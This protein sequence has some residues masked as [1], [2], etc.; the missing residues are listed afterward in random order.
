LR[1]WVAVSLALYVAYWLELDN[2]YWAGTTAAIVC[3]PSLGASL[4][5]A[6]FRMIGT[7]IGAVAV[8]V[9]TACFPQSRAG[10]LIGLA[11]WGATCGFMATLLRNFASYAAALAGYTAVIIASDELAAT[12]SAAGEIFTLAVTRASEICI[13]I[14]CAGV[15]LA[16][17]DFGQARRRLA[18]QFAAISAEIADGLAGTF[19]L[20]GAV[21][22][23]TLPVR[24]DLLRRVIAL[25][26]V[27]DEAIG[28][29]ADLRYRLRG[30][31]AAV[32]GLFTALSGWRM[33]A[34]H[35]GRLPDD[36]RRQAADV[37]LRRIPGE[38][39][40]P[41]RPDDTTGWTADPE[42]LRRL[43][44]GA[45]TA[46]VAVPADTPSLR[47]LADGTAE[48]LVGISRAL[49]GLVLLTGSGQGTRQA[50]VTRLHVPDLLPALVNATRVFIVI[51]TAELFWIATAWPGGSAALAWAAIFVILYSPTADRAYANAR[52]TLIGFFPTAAVA[53]IV[54]FAVLPGCTTF[55]GLALAIGLVLIPAGALSTLP[56]QASLFGTIATWFVQFVAPMNQAIYDTQQFYNSTLAIVAGAAAAT[57]AFHL[58]PPLSPAF[59]VR[60]LLGLTLR[61]L[62]R[63]ATTPV[64]PARGSWE[65]KVYG[66]LSVLP[67][68]AESL[69]R[70]QLLAALS[71]GTEIIRLR[72][73]A[74]RIHL[75]VVLDTALETVAHGQS[76]LSAERLG[77]VH[78]DLAI[79]PGSG[80]RAS[81]TL[82]VQGSIRA[83]SEALVQHASYFD[84]EPFR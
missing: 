3:Q 56:W 19:L 62:R 81:V 27:I 12:G 28:E 80:Q 22:E 18:T 17:T 13:G 50:G 43:C 82:R 31:Q 39:R 42:G 59:R 75:G 51:G 10:F 44:V 23:K 45:V 9:L 48:A 25:D 74:R 11:V 36:P 58:L 7:V 20:A 60:R 41:P 5:K 6:S 72:R 26:S 24:R 65:S 53:A 55:V 32:E 83:I 37:I 52:S 70:A 57:L 21:G 63:L 16:A 66:R 84:S 68:Q 15:V 79:V 61:D 78:D 8:V 2:A 30:L 64:L 49:N 67:E 33:V 29:T 14:V 76:L 47:L 54:K 40:S 35:L 69:Q 46:L 71:V 77:R 4:R 38:L 73:I 34:N 1:L